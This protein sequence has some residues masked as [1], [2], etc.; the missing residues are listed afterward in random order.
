MFA[1]PC[2]ILHAPFANRVHQQYLAL[3][4]DEIPAARIYPII[5]APLQKKPAFFDKRPNMAIFSFWKGRGFPEER[6]G[7]LRR[8]RLY[9]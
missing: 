5:F 4:T 9:G 2:Q 7:A 6:D 1:K 3:R 8:I